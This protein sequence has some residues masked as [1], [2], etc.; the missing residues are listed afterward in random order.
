MKHVF[1]LGIIAAA[2][3]VA[4]VTVLAGSVADAA[5][6]HPFT[7]YFPTDTRTINDLKEIA[8]EADIDEGDLDG[9]LAQTRLYTKGTKLGAMELNLSRFSHVHEMPIYSRDYYCSPLNGKITTDKPSDDTVYIRYT[10]GVGLYDKNAWNNLVA[11]ETY[12]TRVG[13]LGGSGVGTLHI[14]AKLDGDTSTSDYRGYP[15][16]DLPIYG[17]GGDKDLRAYGVLANDDD[18]G[19]A[20]SDPIDQADEYDD[21]FNDLVGGG[22]VNATLQSCLPPFSGEEGDHTSNYSKLSSTDQQDWKD[23]LQQ[24][25][26]TPGDARDSSDGSA[27]GGDIACSG[28]P[29]GWIL[30]PVIN[31][32]A[33][34]TST[35]AGFIDS[36]MAYT[37]LADNPAPIRGAWSGLVGIAN[38]LLVIALLV[39]IFSQ[40]TS[41]GLSSY[42]IKRMLPRLTVAAILINLSFFICAFAVDISNIVGSSITG[43][44]TGSQSIGATI[45]EQLGGSAETGA[46]QNLIGGLAAGVAVV[47]LLAVVFLPVVLAFLLVFLLLAARLVLLSILIIVS[48][49][50]FVAWLLPNTETYFK[51]WWNLFSKLLFVYPMIM[52]LFGASVLVANLINAIDIDAPAV[53]DAG[54]AISS[55]MKLAVLAVPLYA[56]PKLLMSTNAIMGQV[57]NAGQRL[58]RAINSKYG[59][60]TRKR[61]QAYGKF[62]ATYAGRRLARPF[63]ARPGRKPGVLRRGARRTTGGVRNSR[64]FDRMVVAAAEQRKEQQKA[65]LLEHGYKMTTATKNKTLP[66]GTTQKVPTAVASNLQAF[67]GN[68]FGAYAAGQRKA[69]SDE[70]VKQIQADMELGG[71]S[72]DRIAAAMRDALR[73]GD[74][75]KVR[76]AMNQLTNMGAGGQNR[77]YDVLSNAGSPEFYAGAGITPE[78][79]TTVMNAINQNYPTLVNKVGDI[80]KGSF[81]STTG[82]FETTKDGRPTFAALSADQVARQTPDAIMR[83]LDSIS[84]AMATQI[85]SNDNLTA[86]IASPEVLQRLEAIRLG[87]DPHAPPNA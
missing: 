56:V 52:A 42:G 41:L 63:A 25:G 54:G 77:I 51:K 58:N 50:A 6:G 69:A 53:G 67:G 55:L 20:D 39:I 74:H 23:A 60:G 12:P 64:A 29:L 62:G 72:I 70:R 57:G 78:M 34:A 7:L 26:I 4:V 10:L 27:P 87:G 38:I 3:A 49:V 15:A 48:P 75:E 65:D 2:F 84:Q 13:V 61:I 21:Y 5:D 19:I 30:C 32:M 45:N 24:T 47:G 73:S 85:P 44:M 40:A 14:P 43:F 59:E 71:H 36:L 35:L 9:V 37:I 79:Q 80:A 28:G 22:G 33:R 8:E 81:S 17:V 16:A 46:F 76:A 11:D 83:N 1:S 31:L 18:S 82:A 66:D 68:R 86:N